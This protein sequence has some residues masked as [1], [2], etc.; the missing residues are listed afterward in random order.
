MV[1]TTKTTF[2]LSF[3][4]KIASNDFHIVTRTTGIMRS[5][6]TS[7]GTFYIMAGRLKHISKSTLPLLLAISLLFGTS[8]RKKTAE[9]ADPFEKITLGENRTWTN[10]D[11]KYE[12]LIKTLRVGSIDKSSYKGSYLIANDDAVLFLYCEDAL[13]IDGKTSVNPYTTYDIGS[14]SKT[15]TAVSVMQIIEKGKISLHDTIDKFFPDYQEGKN[16]T[17]YHLLHMQSGI[18]DY[19]NT[20]E[21]FWGFTGEW[22]QKDDL[23]SDRITDEEFLSALYA[24]PLDFTPGSKMM[25]CN[26]N[27]QLLA[28]IVEKI[29]GQRF[30]DYLKENIFDPCGMKHTTSMVQGNETAVPLSFKPYYDSG[31]VD[32][33]GHSKQCI[34]ERGDGGIHT[35][36]ADLLA[37]D[38]A[39]FGGKLINS[40]S[41]A[42]MMNFDHGYG[43]GLMPNGNNGCQHGGAAFT[44]S[45]EN[46]ITTLDGGKDHLYVIILEHH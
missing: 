35:C 37:F 39:L 34:R 26:T 40:D 9:N 45:A 27:Y 1:K 6:V 28:M 21:K 36:V 44:Y 17:V 14:T 15:I 13:E 11:P 30:C 46:K 4:A 24:A 16:I 12:D 18:P 5:S 10:E 43:C 25:Y 33:K 20:P 42:E 19:L 3:P 29:S 23:L 32:E 7:G 41:L 38:R 2:F 31:M 8:C 22:K